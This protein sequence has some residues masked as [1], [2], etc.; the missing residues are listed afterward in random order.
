MLKTGIRSLLLGQG[1]CISPLTEKHE[2]LKLIHG[3]RPVVG[4]LELIR[5]GAPR[6][7]GGY[8][9]PNDLEGIE[10]C[11]SPGVSF[12]SSFEK[13]CADLGMRVFLADGSVDAP[14]EKH[15]KFAFIRKFIGASNRPGF[16]TINDWVD[17]VLPGSHSDLL[18][19]IDIEGAEYEAFYRVSD[20]LMSRFRIIVAE[21]HLLDHLWSWPFYQ[22]AAPVFEKILETHTCVHLHPNNCGGSR[23]VDGIEIPAMMEITFLR[24]DRLRGSALA[25]EFPNRLDRDNIDAPSLPLPPCWY[26][27]TAV[28]QSAGGTDQ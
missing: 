8:L 26:G 27:D 10:A 6:G 9:V 18:L 1:K 12:V 23:A 14:A 2:V 19:Q 28:R 15:E 11:F 21:F 4:D 3:L 20:E 17:Q 5:L 25:D 13:D 16:I 22:I 7:D 24:N